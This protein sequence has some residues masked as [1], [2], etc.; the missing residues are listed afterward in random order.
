MDGVSQLR[1]HQFYGNGFQWQTF[2]LLWILEL[3]PFL[4]HSTDSLQVESSYDTQE[5]NYCKLISNISSQ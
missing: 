2:P 5:L 4:S 3:S 1:L